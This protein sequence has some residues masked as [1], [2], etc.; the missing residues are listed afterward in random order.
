MFKAKKN[1]VW[2]KKKKLLVLLDTKSGAYFTLNASGQDLW[3]GHIVEAKPLHEVVSGIAQR[4]TNPPTE[5]QIFADCHKL[6]A[7]WHQNQLI[8]ESED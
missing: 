7:E 3:L 5:E 2:R 1:I 4:Y 6:I 8:E